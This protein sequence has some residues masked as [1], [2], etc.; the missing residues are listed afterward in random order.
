MKIIPLAADSLG[1]RSLATFVE[2]KDCRILIDP[3]VALGPLRFGLPPH[4][5]ELEREEE[6]WN[7]IKEYAK[8]ADVLTVSHYH[9]DHHDPS[10]PEIFKGKTALV[11]HPTENI[12]KSQKGRAAYF[13]KVLEG[14]PKKIEICDGRRFK[15]GGT[16]LRFSRAVPHGIND[17]LGCVTELFIDDGK[18]SFLHTSDIQGPSLREQRDFI[19]N[20]NPDTILCD[21]P[22][23]YMLHRYG[24]KNLEKTEKNVIRIFSKTKV[25]R[26]IFEHH[27]LRELNWKKRIPGIFKAAKKRKVQILTSAEFLGLENDMLEAN[28]KKLHE[29]SEEGN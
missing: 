1:T 10:E 20:C 28:R 14:I 26:F 15:F 7:K 24:R 23:S 2:T 12:N 19:L 27:F 13:L 5:L 21:G 9:Y 11:K 25:K 8:K 4:P 17:R 29:D 6:H 3:A 18:E 16:I 22:L